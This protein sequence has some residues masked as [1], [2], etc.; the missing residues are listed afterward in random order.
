MLF[1]LFPLDKNDILMYN[2]EKEGNGGKRFCLFLAVKG[3]K[4]WEIKN[5]MSVLNFQ[6]S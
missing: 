3:G 1:L 5:M 6:F 2:R 4:Q